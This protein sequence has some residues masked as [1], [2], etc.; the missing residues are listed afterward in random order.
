MSRDLVDGSLVDEGTVG[1][2]LE[3]TLSDLER[4]NGGRESCGELVVDTVLDE[5]TVGTDAVE[6][7]VRG[8]YE[9]IRDRMYQV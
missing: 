8:G 4:S 7:S 9:R 3:V 5:D 1:D 6:E 2:T